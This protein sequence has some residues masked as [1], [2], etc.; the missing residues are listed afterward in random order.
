MRARYRLAFVAAA[1]AVGAVLLTRSRTPHLAVGTAPERASEEEGAS[2]GAVSA[3]LLT[4]APRTARRGPVSGDCRVEGRATKGGAGIAARVVVRRR[5]EALAF[6]RG[7]PWRWTHRRRELELPDSTLVASLDSGPDGTFEVGR[8]RPGEYEL[9]ASDAEGARGREIVAFRVDGDVR[10]VELRLDGGTVRVFGR[11]RWADGRA[12]QGVV[13]VSQGSP[14]DASSGRSSGCVET[15]TTTDG[16]GRYEVR[17]LVAGRARVSAA[18]AGTFRLD[19]P[20]IRLPRTGPLD[21]VVDVTTGVFQGR[22]VD[23]ATGT[24]LA[25]ATVYAESWEADEHGGYGSTVVRVQSDANGEFSIRIRGRLSQVHVHLDGYAPASFD[26]H[27][28]AI[29]TVLPLRRA[30]RLVGRVT[31][32]IDGSPV[33]GLPVVVDTSRYEPAY[34]D[35]DGKY[36]LEDLEP[37]E[38]LVYA[39]GEGWIPQGLRGRARFPSDGDPR[40]RWH[41][42]LAVVEVGK[43]E[44]LDLVVEPGITVRGQVVNEHDQPVLGARV[45]VKGEGD[46]AMGWDGYEP[47]PVAITGSDGRFAIPSLLLGAEYEISVETD[48]SARIRQRL[49]KTTETQ[50]EVSLRLPAPWWITVEVVADSDGAPIQD[51]RIEVRLDEGFSSRGLYGDWVTGAD[52]R[53]TVGPLPPSQFQPIVSAVGYE[54]GRGEERDAATADPAATIVPV[55][56]R[57]LGAPSAPSEPAPTPAERAA[58]EADGNRRAVDEVK[59]EVLVVGGDG[60]AIPFASTGIDGWVEKGKWVVSPKRWNVGSSLTLAIW[61]ATGADGEPLPWGPV[62]ETFDPTETGT[63]TIHLPPEKTVTGV[64]VGPDGRPLDRVE[65]IARPIGTPEAEE[66]HWPT[67]RERARTRA[68]GSFRIGRLAGS[69]YVLTFALPDRMYAP[70]GDF[71]VRGGEAGVRVETHAGVDSTVRALEVNGRPIAGAIVSASQRVWRSDWRR[72]PVQEWFAVETGTTGEDG[73]VILRGLDPRGTYRLEVEAAKSGPARRSIERHAWAP[74]E[75][76]VRLPRIGTVAGTLVDGGGRPL[77]NATVFLRDGE[78]VWRSARTVEDGRFE[79]GRV[80]E[81]EVELAASADLRDE[82]DPAAPISRARSGDTALRIVAPAGKPL[83][84]RV[85]GIPSDDGSSPE[86][87]PWSRSPQVLLWP[88]DRPETTP[89]RA[90]CVDGV[91][92]FRGLVA[93]R[94]YALWIA[95]LGVEA[96]MAWR[97]GVLAGDEPLDVMLGPGKSLRGK[98][99]LHVATGLSILARGPRPGMEVRGRGSSDGSYEVRG[100]V[101]GTWEIRAEL[102]WPG[103]VATDPLIFV[104]TGPAGGSADLLDVSAEGK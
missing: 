77:P 95:P 56:M 22:A 55:R 90:E 36:V 21:V 38:F 53:S 16:D 27:P 35:A 2:A 62:E 37:G 41:P 70:P 51:A 9:E 13:V 87:G 65:V 45:W 91:A 89:I 58:P 23:V 68:D 29:P 6:S 32:S 17:G 102:W 11:M 26:D 5:R 31:S 66:P 14:P 74:R 30:G 20:P 15:A 103:Q 7:E 67:F 63:L 52:G 49:P 44:T 69:E 104:G 59:R 40:P 80:D 73:R 96:V 57:K 43:T 98:T 93:G 47:A 25:G 10:R 42:N 76:T 50:P 97:T 82:L 71:R 61:G 94:P 54:S 3:T 92:R 24:G 72:G 39:R 28:Q 78:G 79:L 64:V 46:A 99:P 34:T 100:L 81:G 8:L 84:V 12:F 1:I 4:A 101:E 18:I 86:R 48:A 60:A 85:T 88:E 83:T 19:L 75:E 33:A